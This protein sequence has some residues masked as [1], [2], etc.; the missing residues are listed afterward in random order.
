MDNLSAVKAMDGSLVRDPRPRDSLSR[1][2]AVVHDATRV[3]LSSVTSLEGANRM[4]EAHAR[5]N[6]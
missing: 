6:S 4:R 5:A 2:Y 3:L 1:P